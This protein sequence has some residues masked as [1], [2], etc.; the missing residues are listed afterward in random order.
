MTR[1]RVSALLF[2]AFSIGYGV[3]AYRIELFPGS[4]HEA[5]TARTLPL[6]LSI[7]GTVI[8]SLMLVSPARGSEA[9]VAFSG[10]RWG[11]VIAMCALMVAYGAT[12]TWLGFVVSTTAF[13][14]GGALLLGERRW[15]VIA[16]LSLPVA[17]GFWL[18]LTKLLGIYLEPGLLL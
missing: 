18:I 9:E 4:E 15:Y 3:L 12:I 8:A 7:A 5:F 17:F 6:G 10:L 13:L 1:D 16:A 2:L 14:I 11:K